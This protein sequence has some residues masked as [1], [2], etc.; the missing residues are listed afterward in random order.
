[1]REFYRV[2]G[3][4]AGIW[5]PL[6]LLLFATG[7]CFRNRALAIEEPAIT[8]PEAYVRHCA[9]SLQYN[10]S[11][12]LPAWVAYHLTAEE[13]NPQCSRTNCFRPDTAV[14]TGSAV[15]QDYY[16][17]GFDRGHLAPAADMCFCRQAMEE[18]FLYS[19]ICPQLSS[20]NR[21][22]WKQLENRV[23][24]WTRSYK[25]LYVCCGPVC[26]NT[27]QFIGPDSVAVPSHFFKTI[28]VYNDTIQSG[29]GFIFP[30]QK[31]SSCLNDYAVSI[32][33][34]EQFTGLDFYPALTD[35]LEARIETMVSISDW[36]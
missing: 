24:N 12:E 13:L 20:F 27:N 1:M 28:L 5:I 8:C 36:Q 2:K 18:S 4:I 32:D 19:N 16:K 31:C 7:A 23:R 9:Y 6:F 15:R 35:A 14:F 25:S 29:I 21:G 33:S 30:H 26:K 11:N 10:E 34:V 17:Q 3:W 22:I